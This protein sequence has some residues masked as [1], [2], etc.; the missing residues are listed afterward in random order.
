M[1]SSGPNPPE[2]VTVA[3]ATAG[4]HDLFPRETKLAEANTGNT[5]KETFYFSQLNNSLENLIVLCNLKLKT[6]F[7]NKY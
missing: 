1:G 2:A 4:G 5:T 6:I 3:L 7:R